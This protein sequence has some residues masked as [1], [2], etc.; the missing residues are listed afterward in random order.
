MMGAPSYLYIYRFNFAVHLFAERFHFSTG[1]MRDVNL[2][3]HYQKRPK[4][5]KNGHV[6]ADDG[7]PVRNQK[8]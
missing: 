8:F 5:A 3:R 2:C 7:Y 6:T 4:T 1:L